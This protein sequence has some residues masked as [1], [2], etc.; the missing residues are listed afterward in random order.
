MA[1]SRFLRFFGHDI[2]QIEGPL[3][4]SARQHPAFAEN[5]THASR[6]CMC[7]TLYSLYQAVNFML[8]ARRVQLHKTLIIRSYFLNH[9]KQN[10]GSPP[11]YTTHTHSCPSHAC[12]SFTQSTVHAIQTAVAITPAASRAH[13]NK[14]RRACCSFTSPPPPPPQPPHRNPP[15][16]PPPPRQPP[17]SP[18][19]RPPPRRSPPPPPCPPPPPP[20]LPPPSCRP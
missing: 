15:P 20:S 10:T 1:S 3:A 17:R 11:G 14:T 2:F 18:P 7:N 16:Q 6:P 12:I 5:F 19:P 4:N 8:A 9:T 13:G